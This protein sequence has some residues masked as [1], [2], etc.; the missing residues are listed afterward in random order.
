FLRKEE[1]TL[2]PVRGRLALGLHACQSVFQYL[3]NVY[4]NASWQGPAMRF[5]EGYLRNGS[6]DIS[7]LEMI[8]E[9]WSAFYQTAEDGPYRDYGAGWTFAGISLLDD[10]KYEDGS[11]LGTI[12]RVPQVFSGVQMFR[13]NLSPFDPIIRQNFGEYVDRLADPIHRM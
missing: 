1:L 4:V 3:S 13:Q 10:L 11:T 7:E 6:Y 9:E 5:I 12:H 8:K 2:L